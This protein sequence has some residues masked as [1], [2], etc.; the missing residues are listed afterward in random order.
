MAGPG[1]P[2]S[3]LEKSFHGCFSCH[4]IAAMLD[5]FN[6]VFFSYDLQL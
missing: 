6:K 2:K 4:V 5:E 1:K 3:V